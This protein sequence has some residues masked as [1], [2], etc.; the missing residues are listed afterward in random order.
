MLEQTNRVHV[1][2]QETLPER[3][4]RT[5]QKLE[6][7]I[8]ASNMV[9]HVIGAKCGSCPHPSQVQDLISRH[10][11]FSDKFP[12]VISAIQNEKA[13]I[14][15]TQ[16]EAWLA[17]FLEKRLLPYVLTDRELDDSQAAHLKRLENTD[18]FATKVW[19][20]DGVYDGIF[21]SMVNL[22]VLDQKQEESNQKRT[23]ALMWVAVILCFVLAGWFAIQSWSDRPSLDESLSIESPESSPDQSL[24][25]PANLIQPDTSTEGRYANFDYYYGRG[26]IPGMLTSSDQLIRDHPRDPE[27]WL[28]HS[29]A[30]FEEG[31]GLEGEA[32]IRAFEKSI[33]SARTALEWAEESPSSVKAPA[34][35]NIGASY[36]RLGKPD[37]ALVELE[38]SVELNPHDRLTW[39]NLFEAHSKSSGG[40]PVDVLRRAFDRFPG[41]EEFQQSF[42]DEIRSASETAGANLDFQ[43]AEQLL[44]ELENIQGKNYHSLFSRYYLEVAKNNLPIALENARQALE[45]SET[46]LEEV[47]AIL[48]IADVR[49]KIEDSYDPSK[50]TQV[51]A[52]WEVIQESLSNNDPNVDRNA[53]IYLA[54]IFHQVMGNHEAADSYRKQLAK[55]SNFRTVAT[56]Q[57]IANDLMSIGQRAGTSQPLIVPGTLKLVRE[58]TDSP[59]KD[60]I[61][62]FSELAEPLAQQDWPSVLIEAEKMKIQASSP[63][64]KYY[65]HLIAGMVYFEQEKFIA[66]EDEFNHVPESYF[67][68]P[69][70]TRRYAAALLNNKSDIKA[71]KILRKLT[72]QDPNDVIAWQQLGAILHEQSN[73][74]ESIRCFRKC[75]DIQPD[76]P[77]HRM[78]LY[79]AL[80]AH[81]NKLWR[82]AKE[83]LNSEDIEELLWAAVD[84]Y[85]DAVESA[86]DDK[87][88]GEARS[89]QAIPLSLLCYTPGWE[90]ELERFARELDSHVARSFH[91]CPVYGFLGT[92]WSRRRLAGDKL[93]PTDPSLKE[94]ASFLKIASSCSGGSV[95]HCWPLDLVGA[96]SRIGEHQEAFEILEQMEEYQFP[97]S[98]RSQAYLNFSRNV[99]IPQEDSGPT[100]KEI[101]M[102]VDCYNRAAELN[103]DFLEAD[104]WY[105]FGKNAQ[106]AGD[107][108]MAESSLNRAAE[109]QPA[110]YGVWIDL[111]RNRLRVWDFPGAFTATYY[112]IFHFPWRDGTQ[113]SQ[114]FPIIGNLFFALIPLIAVALAICMLVRIR[115]NW[116]RRR[117]ALSQTESTECFT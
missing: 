17:L 114:L 60:F 28:K 43:K 41:D 85:E 61:K 14:T 57:R 76:D 24:V 42:L 32:F 117:R 63:A 112:S 73:P 107:Y 82:K 97:S 84:A 30:N 21:I 115:K 92:Y 47:Q 99:A 48:L 70:F 56:A 94:A 102:V 108:H 12:E 55:D 51:M 25:Q 113:Y 79:V 106:M 53:V 91:D 104:D 46:P 67:T 36:L 19:G 7:E 54:F 65:A 15:F 11:D 103:E 100:S 50:E 93:S 71:E 81:G 13:K 40:N 49:S 3:G 34:Y 35:N 38:K 10:P 80:T 62:H 45:M 20:R 66:A 16:W 29:Y 109:L 72:A 39:T 77:V 64:Q 96:L 22:G 9:I 58:L 2:S 90:F 1:R 68:V 23:L 69:A 75:T 74:E 110:Q 18:V 111:A 89:L 98:V 5:L 83:N 101:Q 26:D 105:L 59:L 52:S 88:I 95:L 44:D 4:V 31:K 87:S 86:P 6:E 78:N 116:L 33:Q 8:A 27:A 37:E